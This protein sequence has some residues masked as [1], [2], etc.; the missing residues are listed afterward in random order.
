MFK[1][2]SH[3]LKLKNKVNS[4][5]SGI[6]LTLCQKISELIKVKIQCDSSKNHGTSFKIILDPNDQNLLES[7][8]RP[9]VA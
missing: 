2:F 6:G 4:G 3:Q 9:L 5:G 7:D 8:Q 1:I